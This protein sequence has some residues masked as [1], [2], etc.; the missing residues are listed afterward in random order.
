MN[1]KGPP[2]EP[3]SDS[4]DIPLPLFFWGNPVH[5]KVLPADA[6]LPTLRISPCFLF[7]VFAQD[8][9][10]LP[11]NKKPRDTAVGLGFLTNTK[12]SDAQGVPPKKRPF[13][14]IR[15]WESA[16][17][18]FGIGGAAA[19]DAVADPDGEA[20]DG[21]GYEKRDEGGNAEQEAAPGRADGT[22]EAG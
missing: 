1:K 13:E 16:R 19:Y 20:N 3:K 11:L 21:A 10:S 22:P 9:S 2:P 5:I 4:P 8:A 18:G 15:Q 14:P 6:D 7:W 17:C 12:A